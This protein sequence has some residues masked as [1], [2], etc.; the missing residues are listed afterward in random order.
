MKEDKKTADYSCESLW[1]KHGWCSLQNRQNLSASISI[2]D[3]FYC[4][5]TV[6]SS[7]LSFSHFLW[8]LKRLEK[9]RYTMKCEQFYDDKGCA[10]M[11]E[12]KDAN[13]WYNINTNIVNTLF[14][15]G[16]LWALFGQH[17]TLNEVTECRQFA[18]VQNERFLYR[19]KF[20]IFFFF[21]FFFRINLS[22]VVTKKK[23]HSNAST[24]VF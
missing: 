19:V 2:E 23:F 12:R 17:I 3:D 21:I 8:I 9:L 7:P 20:T 22:L 15:H 1:E 16:W 14:G 24:K 5:V 13:T 4:I 11:N 18:W 6:S 10:W